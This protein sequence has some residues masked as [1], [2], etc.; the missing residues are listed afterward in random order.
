MTEKELRQLEEDQKEKEKQD[1]FNI[2]EM[3]EK[4]YQYYL[5]CFPKCSDLHIDIVGHEKPIVTIYNDSKRQP[6]CYKLNGPGIKNLKKLP[7]TDNDQRVYTKLKSCLEVIEYGHSETNPLMNKANVRTILQS[8]EKDDTKS[9]SFQLFSQVILSH[10]DSENY[11][12][13]RQRLYQKNT[14]LK[15]AN[16]DLQQQINDLNEVIRSLIENAN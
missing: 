15:K 12:S 13:E 10:L 8:W 11:E 1:A 4:L 5:L 16:A 7:K 3:A 6:I 2:C 9:D 14:K